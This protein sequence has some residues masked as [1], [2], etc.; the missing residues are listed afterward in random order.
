[1]VRRRGMPRVLL[2]RK[3]ECMTLEIELLEQLIEDVA[4]IRE[5]LE[6]KERRRKQRLE[7][8]RQAQEFSQR[9]A[10]QR[11]KE[12]CSRQ[13]PKKRMSRRNDR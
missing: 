9:I 2:D 10:Y 1:M 4:R 8:E 11:V 12:E 3:E 7:H 5:L 6:G 13:Y